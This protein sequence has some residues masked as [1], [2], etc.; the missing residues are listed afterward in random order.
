MSS[1]IPL[2]ISLPRRTC[3]ECDACCY[4]MEILEL[5]K[6]QYHYCEHQKPEGGCEIW[7]KKERPNSCTTWNCAWLYNWYPED[8]RP[9]KS[10]IV[11]YPMAAHLS[12]AKIAHIIGQE[13]WDGALNSELGKKAFNI[14]SSRI[15][16]VVRHF[17]CNKFSIAGPEEQVKIWNQNINPQ[18]N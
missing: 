17:A 18:G 1:K 14:L 3:G 10:G 7:G 11:F 13:F 9:D 12:D 2:T 8:C 16:T 4:T 6:Y 15:L 5:K